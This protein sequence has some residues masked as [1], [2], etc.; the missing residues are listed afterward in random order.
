MLWSLTSLLTTKRLHLSALLNLVKGF[1]CFRLNNIL[2]S[3]SF[4]ARWTWVVCGQGSIIIFY[5]KNLLTFWTCSQFW[6]LN[7][8]WIELIQFFFLDKSA[9]MPKSLV[10]KILTAVVSDL[11]LHRRIIQ[12]FL[13][14]ESQNFFNSSVFK[15]SD[16]KFWGTLLCFHDAVL[17]HELLIARCR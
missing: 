8:I 2:L 13:P 11:R 17:T 10:S 14:P 4:F 1:R 5:L 7:L 16:L 9:L 3:I 12:Q 15:Y 6:L